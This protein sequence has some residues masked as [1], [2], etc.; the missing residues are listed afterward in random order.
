MV[1]QAVISTS[2]NSHDE[3]IQSVMCSDN[4]I[5][6]VKVP[7]VGA[8][9]FPSGLVLVTLP[10]DGIGDNKAVLR[11]LA[12][13]E[14]TIR[15]SLSY[16]IPSNGTNPD[17]KITSNSCIKITQENQLALFVHGNE[18]NKPPPN[19]LYVNLT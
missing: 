13:E 17:F 15:V 10:E 4:D 11:I 16:P 9:V 2:H 6:V 3:N 7:M 19:T 5:H 18:D 14:H 1:C 12:E 8:R